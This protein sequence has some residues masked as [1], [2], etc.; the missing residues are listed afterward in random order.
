MLNG[1]SAQVF[2][3]LHC[4]RAFRSCCQFPTT[5]VGVEKLRDRSV[6]L[7]RVSPLPSFCS[8]PWLNR[9][10]HKGCYWPAEEPHQSFDV[11]GHRC[12]EELLPHEPQSA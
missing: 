2:G 10:C 8:L 5:A 9:G 7:V 11:L 4:T 1:Y 6:F 3:K 12:H